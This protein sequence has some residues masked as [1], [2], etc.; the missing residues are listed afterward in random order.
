MSVCESRDGPTRY[1]LGI[2]ILIKYAGGRGSI[3][4]SAKPREVRLG[5]IH[6]GRLH[7][8]GRGVRQKWTHADTGSR[9]SVAKNRRPQIQ[10]LTKI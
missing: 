9:G 5:A 8:R 7:P 3:P 6:E 2:K 4:R 10:I 1:N